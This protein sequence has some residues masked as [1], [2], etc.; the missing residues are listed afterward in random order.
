MTI[1]VRSVQP[2]DRDRL[3][4]WRNNPRVRE[5]SLDDRL[6]DADDHERWF[7][8]LVGGDTSH[9]LIALADNEP[10]GIVRLGDL[11]VT[12]RTASWSCHAGAATLTPGFGACLPVVGLGLGFG[13]FG[14]D[15]MHAEVLGINKNMRGVH[16]RLRLVEEGVRREQAMRA[17][18]ERVDVHEFGVLREEWPEVRNRMMSL[19]PSSISQ[20][21]GDVLEQL[22]NSEPGD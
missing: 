9:V 15:R 10:A 17:D 18:G 8:S 6:I 19:L 11:D 20:S 5:M 7:T 21:L 4:E 3:L 12:N 22:A 16:R 1:A 13:R 2:D 14:L